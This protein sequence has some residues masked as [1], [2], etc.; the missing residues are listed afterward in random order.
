MPVELTKPLGRKIGRIVVIIDLDGLT[1][2]R[3]GK[4][5]GVRYAWTDLFRGHPGDAAEAFAQPAPRGWC[6]QRG[7]VVW[8]RPT[9]RGIKR[10]RVQSVVETLPEPLIFVRSGKGVV[11]V[12]RSQCRPAPLKTDD[13]TQTPLLGDD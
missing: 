9:G 1:I 10:R 11:P 13:P 8:C 12:N 5:T 6:P 3:P 7:D 4:K 2:R